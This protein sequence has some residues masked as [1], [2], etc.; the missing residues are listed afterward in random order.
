MLK[1]TYDIGDVEG[2]RV[3]VR[4]AVKVVRESPSA[5]EQEDLL[6]EIRKMTGITYESLKREL[7]SADQNG[8]APKTEILPVEAKEKNLQAERYVLSSLLFSKKYAENFDIKK[9]RFENP[10][11]AAVADYLQE[12]S[13]EG[14]Q[15][16][17][18]VLYDIVDDSGKE[19]LSAVLALE[20]SEKRDFDETRYFKDC[21][22]TL[23]RRAAEK[24]IDSLTKLCDAEED[25][26][27]RK[28]LTRR[29]MEKIAELNRL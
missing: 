12:C 19:E 4:E 13:A 27:K 26:A 2:K 22:N 6:K 5:A 23:L 1:K 7:D 9:L 29:L 16:K 14:K 28:E 11:H 15:P 3:F 24:E 17:P 8:A 10:V 18:N 21:V 25:V 20:L